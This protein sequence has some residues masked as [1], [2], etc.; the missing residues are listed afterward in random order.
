MQRLFAGAGREACRSVKSFDVQEVGNVCA[1]SIELKRSP[2]RQARTFFETD[3]H[4][5]SLPDVSGVAFFVVF[6]L[7]KSGLNF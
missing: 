6:F 1:K 7:I 2:R 4:K 5:G 3:K